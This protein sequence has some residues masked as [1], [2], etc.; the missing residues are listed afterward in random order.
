M[1]KQVNVSELVPGMMVT[2]VVEQNGPVKIRKVGFIRSLDMIRGLKEMGVTLVEVDLAESLNVETE[3]G[4]TEVVN[5]VPEKSITNTVVKDVV[6]TENGGSAKPTAT[7]RLVA[8]DKQIADVDRQLSQQFHRSLFLPAVDQ[9]PSKW[10]L[11]GKPY[12]M[13]G[14]FILFGF[15]IGLGAS[16]Y[17]TVWMSPNTPVQQKNANA[18]TPVNAIENTQVVVEAH[19]SKQPDLGVQNSLTKEAASTSKSTT[20]PSTNSTSVGSNEEASVATNDTVEEKDEPAIVSTSTSKAS[21][22]SKV[23]KKETQNSL[24]TTTVNGITLEAGQQ[25]LGYQSDNNTQAGSGNKEP[26]SNNNCRTGSSKTNQ[27]TKQAPNEEATREE[28]NESL[29]SDLLRRIQAAAQ[30]LDRYPNEPDPRSLKVTDLNE[31]QRIDQLS[32]ALL[33]QMPA[34]SFSA[35][36]YASNP[37]DRWVRVNSQRVGEGE[38]IA[39]SVILQR[40]EPEKVVLSFKG[41]EFT[42]NALSDW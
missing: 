9:M 10:V 7:Q 31:L 27:L 16:Y 35:H 28:P 4:S 32:P 33:T 20:V 22:T 15:L 23:S 11:Y 12:T 3:Q 37:R 8:S 18:D 36:M 5:T 34:M 29:N 6:N 13:L 40:I 39:N 17:F 41:Q 25:I 42:M 19:P 21:K 24:D 1:R 26:S 2:H 38:E 30:D 14:L